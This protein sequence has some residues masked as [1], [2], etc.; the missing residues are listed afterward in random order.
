MTE[1]GG[2]DR[3][4][5]II[6]NAEPR[7]ALANPSPR[8]RPAFAKLA[9]DLAMTPHPHEHAHGPARG[10]PFRIGTTSFIYRGSWLHNVERLAGRVDDVEILFFEGD[11]ASSLPSR[12]EMRAIAALRAEHGLTLSLHT[13]LNASLA[14][15]SDFER[16]LGVSR[17]LRAIEAAEPLSPDAYVVHVYLGDR[18]GDTPPADVGAWRDRAE[19]SIYTLITA[20]VPPD[21]LCVEQLDYD[22][23]LLEPV[24]QAFD[25]PVALDV[26]HLQRDG[27]DLHGL[28]AHWLPRARL[29]QWHGTDDSGRDHR[30]LDWF[31]E[32][33]ALRMLQA[34]VDASYLGVLT[35]EVFREQDFEQSMSLLE[36]WRA[37]LRPP[38]R[39]NSESVPRR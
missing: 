13:P 29:I 38:P 2:C 15:A 6:E 4:G 30:G 10:L 17:V 31:P 19:R 11:D 24:I 35:L 23:R 9:P 32:A 1:R 34:L 14:S 36:R 37:S 12:E 21:R 16:Q 18:E 27:R 3:R 5:R 25:L 8:T 22:L 33:D 7:A 39:P 20:G 26:G 28:L